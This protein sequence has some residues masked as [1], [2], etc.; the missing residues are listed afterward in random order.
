MR[1]PAF[2]MQLLC[3]ASA[4][5][6]LAACSSDTDRSEA[7]GA[8]AS[9]LAKPDAGI[10]APDAGLAVPDAGV[11][12]GLPANPENG[13]WLTY[14]FSGTADPAEGPAVDLRAVIARYAPSDPTPKEKQP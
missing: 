1:N 4:L 14:A 11:G 7:Q 2:S 5:T 6:L 3:C 8:D 12:A 13:L 10:A 9:G